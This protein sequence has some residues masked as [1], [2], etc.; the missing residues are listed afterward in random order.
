MSGQAFCNLE[1]DPSEEPI[2][3]DDFY[4]VGDDNS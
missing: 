3:D 4:F 2:L 1:M